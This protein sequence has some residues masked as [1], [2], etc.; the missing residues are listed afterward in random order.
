[1]AQTTTTDRYYQ[2]FNSSAHSPEN[3]ITTHG[4]IDQPNQRGKLDIL[5]SCLVTI[6]L[7]S[8]SSLFLLAVL[9]SDRANRKIHAS[10]KKV[11]HN[12]YHYCSRSKPTNAQ[13]PDTRSCQPSSRAAARPTLPP[14]PCLTTRIVVVRSYG[15]GNMQQT[16][17]IE[18]QVSITPR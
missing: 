13:P 4:W 16:P 11:I 2:M 3:T 14:Q 17:D 8:W 5:T 6:F 10:V 7:C 15:A 12:H 1:M 18:Q 9:H